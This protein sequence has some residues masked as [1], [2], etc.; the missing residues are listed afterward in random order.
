M[1][2]ISPDVFK[3]EKRA[4]ALIRAMEPLIENDPVGV[5]KFCVQ[6][7]VS[8]G[9]IAVAY[10]T[11]AKAL[12]KL[13]NPGALDQFAIVAR[14]HGRTLI[15]AGKLD[16]GAAFFAEVAETFPD[17]CR[18]YYLLFDQIKA[19]TAAYRSMA[20]PEPAHPPT[21]RLMISVTLWGERYVDMFTRYF[22]PSL[23][24]AHNVPEL[25]QIREVCF[26]LYTTAREIEA[27]RNAPSIRSLGRYADI[28]FTL[29][30]HEILSSAE[31]AQNPDFRYQIYGSFHHLSVERARALNADLICINPDSVYSDGALTTYARLVDHG[32]RA[33]LGTAM[34]G[35]AETLLPLLDKLREPDSQV[36][37]LAPR[38]LVE[39][40]L[41]NIHHAY[42]GFV[43]TK[44]NR[45]MPRD[46]SVL[47]FPHPHG[48]YMRCLHIHPMIFAAELLK[49]DIVF[50]YH[51][52]DANALGRFFP[53]PEDWK[54]IKVMQDSDDGFVM[55]LSYSYDEGPRQDREFSLDYLVARGRDYL[56][57]HLWTFTH[58]INFH[59]DNPI[60]AIGTFDRRPDGSLQRKLLP[61]AD[62]IDLSDEEV[63]REFEDRRLKAA[64]PAATAES[65]V[66]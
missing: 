36:L 19:L 43:L 18:P 61:V 35:Q 16:A 39:M 62:K 25:S 6:A 65:P 27:I 26:D 31:Y 47:L 30:P 21:R 7:I 3:D 5:A 13:N 51:T 15:R 38:Q 54:H 66:G 10:P 37:A 9:F 64:P 56:P 44:G 63:V 1:T 20:F 58:R 33:V 40:D 45:D 24:A 23:L 60:E 2:E 52:V 4:T 8:N 22:V 46:P 48:V 42:K 17:H 49:K 41:Q 50:D 11:L 57:Q 29:F 12:K 53:Q 59:S 14:D 55:D 32:Y 34:R 28:Q